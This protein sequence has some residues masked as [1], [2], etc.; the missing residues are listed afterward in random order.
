MNKLDNFDELIK[1]SLE[2]YQAPANPNAWADMSQRL[3]QMG[4]A[5]STGISTGTYFGAAAVTAG[6]V[7]GGIYL[8]GGEAEVAPATTPIAVISA[9]EYKPDT[10]AIPFASEDHTASYT[11]AI[12]N[13]D[14]PALQTPNTPAPVQGQTPIQT[15][16]NPD[17]DLPNDG[18]AST[19]DIVEQPTT[20]QDAGSP[21]VNGGTPNQTVATPFVPV[22][23]FQM[24]V[25]E[26]CEG[27]QV[28]FTPEHTNF[29][30]DFLW[31]FGD[32]SFSGQKTPQHVFTES[33]EYLIT[34]TIRSREDNSALS[35]TAEQIVRVL[36]AP[37]ANF[38][39]EVSEHN[40]IPSIEFIN[41]TDQALDYKWTFG[42]G[43]ESVRKDPDH[44]FQRKG[45]Y[46]VT[47]EAT[48][49][50]GCVS[51]M[52]KSVRIQNSYNLFAPTGFSP[53]GNSLNENWI[54][55]AL[56]VLNVDFVL[57]VLDQ[58]GKRVYE[59]KE[60]N[61]PWDGRDMNGNIRYGSTFVWICI[62]ENQYG[63]EEVYK[64][65]VTLTR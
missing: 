20:P 45:N 41:L 17:V 37:E 9:V 62:V 48:N 3:D 52:T 60:V 5:A 33:G 57:T 12:E 6:L 8:F 58:N 22:A 31:N 40:V 51:T 13:Q 26:G 42:D 1:G 19:N 27:L 46:Q 15:P 21:N 2:N 25:T 56:E 47:L 49:S 7:I 39:W 55:R 34:L 16:V 38:A 24:N 4:G 14:N 30:G 65:T 29:D 43:A 54:P 18:G 28:Q 59:T 36:E 63:E 61:R 50:Y 11:D 23:D 44:A 32:G 64:G 35:T 10:E 53:D